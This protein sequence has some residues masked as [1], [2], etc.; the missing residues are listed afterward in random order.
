MKMLS[1]ERRSEGE[2]TR[3]KLV[4]DCMYNKESNENFLYPEGLTASVQKEF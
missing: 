1:E 4:L 2:R 3:L